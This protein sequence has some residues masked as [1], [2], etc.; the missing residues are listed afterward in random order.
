[1]TTITEHVTPAVI[2]SP[3]WPSLPVPATAIGDER[4]IRAAGHAAQLL[5]SVVHDALVDFADAA[6]Q[7]GALVLRGVPVGTLPHTP[8]SPTTPTLPSALPRTH[9]HAPPCNVCHA[10]GCNR[11]LWGK[12]IG[13]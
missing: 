7:S 8:D 4:F 1:M 5:P 12:P 9:T 11:S 10:L 2:E 3:A 6:P 13:L